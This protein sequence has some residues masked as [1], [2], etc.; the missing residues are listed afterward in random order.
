MYLFKENGGFFFFDYGFVQ[1]EINIESEAETKILFL[2]MGMI[3]LP[4]LVIFPLIQLLSGEIYQ[5]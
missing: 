5:N 3:L 4:S 2:S 1:S